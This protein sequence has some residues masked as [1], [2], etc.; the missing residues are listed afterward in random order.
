MIEKEFPILEFDQE[1]DA[2]IRPSSI[3]QPV[4][5]AE[6]CVLCFFSEAIEKI[7][8]E[9]PHRIVA[10]VSAESF[11]FPVYELDYNGE[12]IAL[13]QAGVGAPVAGAQIEELTAFGCK[14][15][16]A[17]GS[18]GVLQKEIAVGHLIIPTSAVRDEGTSYHYVA[19][20]REITAN[21][22]VV[23]TIE[24]AL[25]VQQIPYIKAKTW[26]TDAFYRETPLKIE[27]RKKEGC[28]TVEM[29]ASAYMAVAQYNGVEFG[30]IL[31]AGDN[32][33]GEIWDG[34]SFNSRTEIREFVLRLA[35][36]VCTK[37]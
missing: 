13:I 17:C 20:S 22:N 9:Y 36:D 4:D 5:I 14:K 27:Q 7:L 24:H 37:L 2:F 26:T 18:C 11:N 33:G 23:Q 21:G 15:Y 34:R 25:A 29:E 8:A 10:N 3:I 28:V 19:P 30:Q 31:Y 6:K 12:K 16:I 1:K 35:L 32:L